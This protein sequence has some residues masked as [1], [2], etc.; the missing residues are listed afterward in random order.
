[1]G[2]RWQFSDDPAHQIT[3][4]GRM[5]YNFRGVNI[6]KCEISWHHVNTF[7]DFTYNNFTYD[8]YKGNITYIC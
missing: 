1:M 2:D 8:I 5:L 4:Q 3:D 6:E 7:K